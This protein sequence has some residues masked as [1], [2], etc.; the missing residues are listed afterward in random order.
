MWGLP[1]EVSGK[2]QVDISLE[3]GAGLREVVST[4]KR[5]LPALTGAVL[6]P[7]DDRLEDTCAFNLDG[8]FLGE[9]EDV[10]LHDGDRIRLLTLATGG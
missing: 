10:S 2:S 6:N 3:D 7:H 9:G 1:R 5:E 4:L 8:R